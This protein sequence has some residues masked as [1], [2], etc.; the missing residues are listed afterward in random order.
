MNPSSI[1]KR[2]HGA[3][4]LVS[5]DAEGFLYYDPSGRMSVQSAP[6]RARPRA[7]EKPTPAEALAALDGYVAYFGT[8]AIDAAART[9]THHQLATVQPGAPTPLVRTY[10]LV[11]DDRLILRP[12]GRPGEIVWQRIGGAS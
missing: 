5:P 2:F 12:L 7:G 10:E 8:Y 1:G 9:V 4:R 6:R 3:W 11:G